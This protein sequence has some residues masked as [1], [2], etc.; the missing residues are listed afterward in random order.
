LV[1]PIKRVKRQWLRELRAERN[2]KTREIAEHFGISY[3][4]YNDIETGRRNPSFE[5]SQEMAA[6]FDCPLEKFFEDRTKFIKG[7]N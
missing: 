1:K 6:F 2:L 5:L 4:H 7:E 3:Q